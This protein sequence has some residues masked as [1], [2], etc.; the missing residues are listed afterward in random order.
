MTYDFQSRLDKAGERMKVVN[1]RAGIYRRGSD[2]VHI[3]V[4]PLAVDRQELAL[5][6]IVLVSE[7]RQDY[8]FDAEDLVLAGKS[9]RPRRG[10]S[11]EVDGRTHEIQPIGDTLWKWVTS[12]HRRIR[13][14]TKATSDSQVS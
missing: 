4:S 3:T 9:T 6:G 12:S 8:A 13:V 7:D 14:H 10:D 1:G 11:I 2:I 5:H